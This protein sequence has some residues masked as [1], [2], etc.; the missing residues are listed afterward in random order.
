MN[1]LFLVLA[2]LFAVFIRET[3]DEG[4]PEDSKTK[5]KGRGMD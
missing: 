2:L 4:E 5:S 1:K 3:H